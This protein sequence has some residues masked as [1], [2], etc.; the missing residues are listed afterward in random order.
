[1]KAIKAVIDYLYIDK[2]K[3]KNGV[4]THSYGINQT[5]Y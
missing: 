5:G 2:H 1:M 3:K 4:S